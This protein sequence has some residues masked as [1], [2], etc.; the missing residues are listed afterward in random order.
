MVFS[1]GAAT[2]GPGMVVSS[3]LREP[4]RSHHDIEKDSV[5][6]YKRAIKVGKSR[7]TFNSVHTHSSSSTKVSPDVHQLMV[8]LSTCSRDAWIKSVCWR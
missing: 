8:M 5:K 6:H 1:G 2:E 3:E 4:I 7:N